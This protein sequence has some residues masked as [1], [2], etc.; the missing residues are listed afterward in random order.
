MKT[1]HRLAAV[2]AIAFSAFAFA[3]I[4]GT[5]AMAALPSHPDAYCLTYEKGASVCEYATI[6]QCE[7]T[8]SGIGGQCDLNYY[9]AEDS[10]HYGAKVS[11]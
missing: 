7:A 3:A 5:P 9:R 6:A 11:R 10:A 1:V 2:P 8:A 4:A